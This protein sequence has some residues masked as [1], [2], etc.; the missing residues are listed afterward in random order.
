MRTGRYGNGGSLAVGDVGIH[1]ADVRGV[2]VEFRVFRL[3]TL[4][5]PFQRSE[6][7]GVDHVLRH[8]VESGL[9]VASND[10]VG[11]HAFLREHAPP[12]LERGK[13]AIHAGR[14]VGLDRTV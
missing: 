8:H 4:E 9:A 2:R 5:R 14:S 13:T 6:V 7:P 10:F 1:R 11:I 3:E 12:K